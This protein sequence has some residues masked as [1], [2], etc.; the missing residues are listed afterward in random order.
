MFFLCFVCCRSV[1]GAV[2][3]AGIRKCRALSGHIFL[4][5]VLFSGCVSSPF[6]K[7]L[8]P[9]LT[10][11]AAQ[12]LDPKLNPTYPQPQTLN[13]PKPKPLGRQTCHHA[14]KKKPKPYPYRVGFSAWELAASRV[15]L[16]VWRSVKARVIE[17]FVSEKGVL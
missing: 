7:A 4:Y 5:V 9:T 16:W 10:K 3:C 8:N 12:T 17:G 2:E 14:L 1:L 15:G 11:P 13:N 6:R